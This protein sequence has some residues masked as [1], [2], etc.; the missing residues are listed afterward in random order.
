MAN[1]K[2]APNRKPPATGAKAYCPFS[3]YN[4]DSWHIVIAGS[5]R[6]QYE[7]AVMTPAAKPRET[8]RSFL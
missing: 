1:T 3:P 4:F 2:A 5:K 7:A 6:D 8:S